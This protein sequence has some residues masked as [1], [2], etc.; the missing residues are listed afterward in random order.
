[1]FLKA[2][3]ISILIASGFGIVL[4][5]IDLYNTIPITYRPFI[6]G[7]LAFILMVATIYGILWLD[8]DIEV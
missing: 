4:A 3:G 7:V 5:A 8:K 1:M 2:F 6:T